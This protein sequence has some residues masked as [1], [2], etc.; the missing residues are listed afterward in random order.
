M[1][2]ASLPAESLAIAIALADTGD[3]AEAGAALGIGKRTAAARIGQL[4]REI[5]AVL[6]DHAG[7][8][9]S[10]T[11]AGEV[12][13]AEAR[14]SLAAAARAAR[15][16]RDVAERADTIGI[17]V[18]DD[19]MLGPL[20]DLFEA[21]AWIDAGF[22]PALHHGPLDAQMAALAEGRVAMVFTSPPLPAHPRILHLSLIHI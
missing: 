3:L 10:L 11:R 21:P 14:L 4:E 13:I 6:F 15:L 18:T 1:A 7:K 17:G 20:R 12:F 9:V 2:D 22:L 16:A 5:G 19:A 8:A